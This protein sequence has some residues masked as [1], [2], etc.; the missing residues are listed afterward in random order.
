MIIRLVLTNARV[1]LNEHR[2]GTLCGARPT[3][4]DWISGSDYAL[5]SNFALSTNQSLWHM[6][7][8][9]AAFIS[10]AAANSVQQP[11][12]LLSALIS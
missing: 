1:L 12:L 5:D 8:I 7:P 3:V 2:V 10:M 11:R 4:I 9:I 6:H